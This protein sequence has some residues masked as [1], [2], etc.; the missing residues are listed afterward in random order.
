MLSERVVDVNDENLP[1]GLS[2]INHGVGSQ[3]LDEN[4]LA[5]VVLNRADLADVKRIIVAYTNQ[6]GTAFREH[7]A[8][9]EDQVRSPRAMW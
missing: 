1:V 6:R 4:N 9:E 3:N 8:D 7:E 2:L 5:S